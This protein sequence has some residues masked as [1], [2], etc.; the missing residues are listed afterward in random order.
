MKIINQKKSNNKLILFLSALAGV[1]LLFTII[2][3]SLG[4]LGKKK[5]FEVDMA[6]VSFNTIV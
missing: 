2:G 5:M 3:K 4:W 6:K 1:L